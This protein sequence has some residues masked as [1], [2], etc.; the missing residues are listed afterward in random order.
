MIFH[1]FDKSGTVIYTDDTCSEVKFL[2][3]KIYVFYMY[4]YVHVIYVISD[5]D[6]GI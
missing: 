5:R 6:A 1:E 2:S 3:D 4:M